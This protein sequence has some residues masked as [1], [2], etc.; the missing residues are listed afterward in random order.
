MLPDVS[1]RGCEGISP[2]KFWAN[3]ERLVDLAKGGDKIA[4]EEAVATLQLRHKKIDSG[5]VSGGSAERRPQSGSRNGGAPTEG[6]TSNAEGSGND[7]ME[8]PWQPGG[9]ELHA[10]LGATGEEAG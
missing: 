6:N 1:A 3:S 9:P 10:V 2:E 4:F 5:S 7:G 8:Q